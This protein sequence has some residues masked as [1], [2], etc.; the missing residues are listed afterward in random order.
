M[1]KKFLP[2]NSCFNITTETYNG[3]EQSPKGLGISAVAYNI[4]YEMNGKDNLIWSVQMKN[5]KKVWFRKNGMPVV[6]HEEPIITEIP[7]EVS[8]S[9]IEDIPVQPQE[10]PKVIKKTDYNLFYS[11]YTNK[12][13]E[14]NKKNGIKKENKEI[15]D[16]TI[17]EWNRLK[18]NKKELE[19]L[20]ISIKNKT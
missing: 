8:E 20:M 1:I 18:K 2:T 15:K 3:K 11:Y 16:T 12:L 9:I 13:K 14:E 17:T 6:T 7:K 5:N 4:G 19:L 10:I